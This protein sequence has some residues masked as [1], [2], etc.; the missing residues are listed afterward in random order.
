MNLPKSFRTSSSVFGALFVFGVEVKYN[1][2]QLHR[3][4]VK[5]T[6]ISCPTQDLQKQSIENR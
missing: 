2:Q 3:Q 1:G 4:Q 5:G 6:I